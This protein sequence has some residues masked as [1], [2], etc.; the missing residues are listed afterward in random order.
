VSLNELAE[1]DNEFLIEDDVLGFADAIT[2][3]DA[4]GAAHALKGI[5]NSRGTDIDPG[6]GATV[7][8]TVASVTLRLSSL[9]GG[10]PAE[11][12]EVEVRR[13][14]TLLCR[15]YVNGDPMIDRS[16]GRVTCLLRGVTY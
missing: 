13:A 8:G 7:I 2:W 1:S 4:L 11:K 14:G 3:T 5:Y 12:D 9:S 15:G 10:M 16:S 6:T